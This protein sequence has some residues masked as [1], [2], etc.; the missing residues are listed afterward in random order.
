MKLSGNIIDCHIHLGHWFEADGADYFTA[1]DRVQQAAGL[2]NICIQSL[3]DPP[4]GGSDINIMAAL[5]KRHAPSAYAYG[6]LICP[7][8][9]VFPAGMDPLTQYHELMSMGFDGIKILYAPDLLREAMVPINDPVYE[10]FF[11]QAEADGTPFMW[12]VADPEQFWEGPDCRFGQEHPTYEEMFRQV[13]AVMGKHPALRVT[14]AHFLF[15]ER[16]P[17]KLEEVFRAYPNVRVD[18]A[19]GTHFW[20]FAKQPEYFRAF[21]ERYA[22]RILFGSDSFVPDNPNSVDLIENVYTWI[23]SNERG[24]AWGFEMDGLRLSADACEKIFRHNFTDFHP[25]GPKAVQPSA[26][27]DYAKKY[28]SYMVYAENRAPIQ[29]YLDAQI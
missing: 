8:G 21:L 20:E 29:A 4:H 11:A 28:G 10:P 13:F 1:L 2:E 19:P 9:G 7:R 22:D 23:A 16:Y 26:I 14:F 3:G 6:S 15:L 5:Y 24:H 27:K 12:H 18:L 17:R 25:N